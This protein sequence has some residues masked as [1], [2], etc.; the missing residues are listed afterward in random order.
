MGL[1][2]ILPDLVTKVKDLVALTPV[3]GAISRPGVPLHACV[4]LLIHLTCYLAIFMAPFYR[5][6]EFFNFA[7]DFLHMIYIVVHFISL[8]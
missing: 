7:F 2:K 4:R 3:L 6:G 8:F 1:C 5:N